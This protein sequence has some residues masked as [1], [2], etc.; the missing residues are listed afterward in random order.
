MF[1][2]KDFGSLDDTKIYA[3]FRKKV[4]KNLRGPESVRR[5]GYKTINLKPFCNFSPELQ[6]NLRKSIIF[7]WQEISQI[8]KSESFFS[9][10]FRFINQ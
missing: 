4:S 8:K 5:K 7:P 6:S 10:N 1:A 9:K 3:K 2:Q